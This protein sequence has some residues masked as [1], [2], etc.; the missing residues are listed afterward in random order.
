MSYGKKEKNYFKRY[1]SWYMD[2]VLEHNHQ[3]KTVYAFAKANNF[4]EQLF[5]EFFGSFD[6]VEKSD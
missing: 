2:Y 4:D 6:A 3:P 1:Y 5:Y